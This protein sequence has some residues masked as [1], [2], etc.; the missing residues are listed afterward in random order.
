[1]VLLE[2]YNIDPFSIEDEQAIKSSLMRWKNLG[3][4]GGKPGHPPFVRKNLD[5]HHSSCSSIH[6]RTSM[7]GGTICENI[8]CPGSSLKILGVQ[9]L[10]L[11]ILGVQDLPRR[12][13]VS[14]IFQ[15]LHC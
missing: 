5:T 9:D 7:V 10:P 11:K 13:W 6:V 1:M 12:Y 3:K 8:G 4:P 14:R 15:D 2:K